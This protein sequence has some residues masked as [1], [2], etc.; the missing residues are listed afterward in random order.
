MAIL[1]RAMTKSFI[2]MHQSLRRL[3][4]Q[5]QMARTDM[6]QY[7]VTNAASLMHL[8]P[9]SEPNSAGISSMAGTNMKVPEAS[10]LTTPETA[11]ISPI[12]KNVAAS[13]V[14]L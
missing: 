13:G 4:T 14:Y 12:Q 7:P 6:P 11:S 8:L 5:H 9:Y 3:R 10:D 1:I 2:N